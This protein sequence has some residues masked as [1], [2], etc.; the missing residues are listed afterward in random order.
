M[1]RAP[2]PQ[3]PRPRIANS[4]C[5]AFLDSGC[6]IRRGG[7]AC[8]AEG[9]RSA[10]ETTHQHTT[11]QRGRTESAGTGTHASLQERAVQDLLR[12][13]ATWPTQLPET[14]GRVSLLGEL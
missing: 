13:L 9:G 5:S 10:P 3:R 2:R 12:V 6:E 1:R 7:G 14:I 11:T 4:R 8:R